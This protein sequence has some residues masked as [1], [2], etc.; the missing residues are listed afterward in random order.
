MEQLCVGMS[1]TVDV[2]AGFFFTKVVMSAY[3]LCDLIL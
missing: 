1:V 3:F 2:L